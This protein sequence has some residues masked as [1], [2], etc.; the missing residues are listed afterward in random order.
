MELIEATTHRAQIILAERSR[1]KV[2]GSI[3]RECLDHMIVFNAQ[4]LRRVLN[5]YLVYYNETRTHLAPAKDAPIPRAASPPDDGGYGTT[6]PGSSQFT[7]TTPL[8]GLHH[9]YERCTA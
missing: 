1:R 5:A 2:I 4:H 6:L 9:R 3:R 7:L 8:G